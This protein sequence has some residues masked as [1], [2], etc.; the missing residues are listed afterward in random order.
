MSS[1]KTSSFRDLAIGAKFTFEGKSYTKFDSDLGTE[2]N[3]ENRGMKF[4]P[5]DVV[6]P[7]QESGGS[8]NK[9][10]DSVE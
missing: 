7:H 6:V 1:Q 9:N 3:T 10:A 8:E 4:Y 2:A 5:E